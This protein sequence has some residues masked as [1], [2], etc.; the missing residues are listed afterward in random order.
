[1]AAEPFRLEV[2]LHRPIAREFLIQAGDPT[3]E[4]EYIPGPMG[5]PVKRRKLAPVEGLVELHEANI[6]RVTQVWDDLAAFRLC[7]RFEVGQLLPGNVFWRP[8]KDDGVIWHGRGY[9]EAGF[10][11]DRPVSEKR[12][13]ESVQKVAPLASGFIRTRA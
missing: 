2:L 11:V 1:M 7:I 13:L 9:V 6:L 10:V 4:F 3:E 8:R 5:R 12:I